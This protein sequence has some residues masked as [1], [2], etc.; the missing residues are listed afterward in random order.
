[1]A[2]WAPSGCPSGGWPSEAEHNTWMTWNQHHQWHEPQR[3]PASSSPAAATPPVERS[4]PATPDIAHMR[5]GKLET[6]LSLSTMWGESEMADLD[7]S[8]AY[9]EEEMA[10][11]RLSFLEAI[12]KH[13]EL[14]PWCLDF[15]TEQK[16]GMQRGFV[17]GDMLKAFAIIR[18]SRRAPPWEEP[19]TAM[20]SWRHWATSQPNL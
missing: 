9:D 11:L 2:D 17:A 8:G 16:S 6:A 10:S 3:A 5:P 12:V 1:M 20:D 13:S 18:R 15:N 4:A 19:V 14:P 7:G